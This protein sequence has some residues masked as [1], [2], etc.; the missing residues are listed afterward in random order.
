MLNVS[1]SLLILVVT[2]N[3]YGYSLCCSEGNRR[4]GRLTHVPEVQQPRKGVGRIRFKSSFYHQFTV[5][6]GNELR[7][8][9]SSIPRT[10]TG[11]FVPE[12]QC[13]RNSI[14]GT[15]AAPNPCLGLSFPTTKSP[16][17]F[18]VTGCELRHEP[19]QH[20]E[21]KMWGRV[22]ASFMLR[23]HGVPEYTTTLS[24]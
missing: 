1:H 10:F 21:E 11:D 16:W 5:T 7:D 17:P 24:N 12:T 19:V 2:L 8:I 3:L 4:Q 20:G 15:D 18:Q 9:N 23:H 13:K 14:W 6:P 22:R